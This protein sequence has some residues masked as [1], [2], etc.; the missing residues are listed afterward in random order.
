MG[1]ELQPLTW[2]STAAQRQHVRDVA[3]LDR[4]FD[5]ARTEIIAVGEV[6]D[7]AITEAMKVN[8]VR[9]QAEHMAPDGAEHYAYVAFRGVL[10]MVS[11]IDRL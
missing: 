7:T 11:V 6:T 5:L 4:K 8:L 3:T 1:G 2:R 9:A 10:R